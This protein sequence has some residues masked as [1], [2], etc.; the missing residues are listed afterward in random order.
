MAWQ[1]K[2]RHLYN[3]MGHQDSSI[4]FLSLTNPMNLTVPISLARP[5]TDV[6][7]V[8][9]LR[10]SAVADSVRSH[11]T[12]W[13]SPEERDRLATYHR[14]IDHDRFIY[15][16]GG[17]RYLLASYLGQAPKSVHLVYGRHGKPNLP[18][19]S[20]SLQFNVAHSGDWIIWGFSCRSLVG[21]DVEIWQPRRRLSALIQHCLTV[22]EQAQLSAIPATQL[23]QFLHYW[24]VKEAHLKA[25]GWGLS[26]PLNQV[27]VMLE[28]TPRLVHAAPVP[29]K[30]DL[31]WQIEL[32][33]PDARAI[34]AVCVSQEP[35]QGPCQIRHFWL[36]PTS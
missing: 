18:Q 4:G 29:D 25:I 33:Q 31:D 12:A 26:H 17:L 8:W 28:P 19:R 20:G 6:V 1:D 15:S 32:W 13:L 35:G 27:Q 7:H 24:T 21:V 36:T 30:P 16:R 10:C 34:A 23:G 5:Q 9:H 22:E 14:Q 3:M 11:W 2:S